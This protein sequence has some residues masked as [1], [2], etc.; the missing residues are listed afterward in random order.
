MNML[1]SD[2]PGP[3]V[4]RVRRRPSEYAVSFLPE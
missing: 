2:H 3:K 4:P 1:Q